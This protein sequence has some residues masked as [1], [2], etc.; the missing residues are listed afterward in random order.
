MPTGV[1]MQPDHSVHDER[2]EDLPVGLRPDQ[3]IDFPDGIPGFPGNRRFSIVS[4][5]PDTDFQLLQSLDDEAVAMVVAVPWLFFPDYA[6]QLPESDT[7]DLD[8][9]S[10]DD[11]VVF[12]S[13][14]LDA[15]NR[16]AFLNLMGPFVVNARTRQGRQVVLAEG[17]H[18]LRAP[19]D[20]G[21]R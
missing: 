8:L 2:G 20:L 1:R 11:A 6:P 3:V 16:R 5:A 4:L 17:D 14:T 13:V 21:G 12:C 19:V 18:P 10:A 15:A 7:R 9:A